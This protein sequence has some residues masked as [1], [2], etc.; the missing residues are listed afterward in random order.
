MRNVN[1]FCKIAMN[2]RDKTCYAGCS[3][4]TGYDSD[5]TDER[6]VCLIGHA[7]RSGLL[8]GIDPW[9]AMDLAGLRNNRWH[10]IFEATPEHYMIFPKLPQSEVLNFPGEVYYDECVKFLKQHKCL[11]HLRRMENAA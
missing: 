10:T 11:S 3:G 1:L 4:I 8:E 6:P 9:D 2:I 7:W 5:H